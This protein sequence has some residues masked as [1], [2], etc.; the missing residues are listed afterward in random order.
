MIN[1]IPDNLIP[2]TFYQNG[3]YFKIDGRG[4]A[5]INLKETESTLWYDTTTIQIKG[6]INSIVNAFQ[7]EDIIIMCD[8]SGKRIGSSSMDHIN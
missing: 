1:D 8:G 2:V 3:E 4:V 5:E 7:H 6:Q